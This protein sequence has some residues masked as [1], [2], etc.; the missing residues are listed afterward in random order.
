MQW[1]AM[2]KAAIHKNRDALAPKNKVG[3]PHQR[4]VPSPT[5]N[6]ICLE[7]CNESEFGGA[8]AFRAN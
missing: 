8:I 4:K 1:T 3:L 5:D 7:D 6:A 2:P